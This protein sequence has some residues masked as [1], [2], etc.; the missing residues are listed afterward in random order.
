MSLLACGQGSPPPLFRRL[1]GT[2][3][4]IYALEVMA[5]VHEFVISP[6][7]NYKIM[8]MPPKAKNLIKNVRIEFK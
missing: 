3:Q 1:R 7:N 6:R 5:Q 8:R 2:E 4:Y